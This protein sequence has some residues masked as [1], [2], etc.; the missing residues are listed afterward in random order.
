M[1]RIR[2]AAF[3]ATVILAIVSPIVANAQLASGLEGASGST[4]GPDGAL[5]ATEALTGSIARVDPT[6]GEV[7]TFATG[8]PPQLPWVGF[9]GAFD[10]AFLDGV[11]YAIVTVVDFTVGGADISGVYRMDDENTFTPIADIGQ[12]ALDN[13]PALPV[14]LPTG[15][16]Y[17]METYRGGFLVADGH[18]NRVLRVRL[19]GEVSVQKAFGNIVPTGLEVRGNEIY[20]AQAGPAPHLPA[21]GKVVVFTDKTPATDFASGAMLA[22]DVEFGLGRS[23]YVLSQGI[24]NGAFPGSA[25]LPDT[26]ALYEVNQDGTLSLVADELNLPTS[27]EFIGNNAYIVT[28]VGDVWRI[29]NAGQPPFGRGPQR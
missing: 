17:S 8:L 28:L 16:Q 15:V 5:Y 27:M 11:A 24:W 9:G 13:P 3:L 2:K 12:F 1:N 4:V 25:A 29:E 19:N 26:G 21:D 23:L 20:M 6:T 18:H 22:V 14:D 10:V 7:T